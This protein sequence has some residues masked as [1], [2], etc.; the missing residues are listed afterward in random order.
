MAQADSQSTSHRAFS[1][2]PETRI[3]AR[4]GISPSAVPIPDAMAVSDPKA[5]DPI[6]A[7]IEAHKSE[8]DRRNQTI[9][10]ICATEERL[11]LEERDSWHRYEAASITL[12]TTKP[13][14]MD[15][16]IALLSY[17]A[18]PECS[19]PGKSE[20]ILDGA[21]FSSNRDAVAAAERFPALNAEVLREIAGER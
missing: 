21:R 16:V 10:T 6:F 18:L 13:T 1:D 9:E 7:A 17:V 15:G 14:T 11:K 12:L 5:A 4:I 2:G 3:V 8:L 19:G 20:S